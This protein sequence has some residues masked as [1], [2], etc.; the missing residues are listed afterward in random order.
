MRKEKGPD[1]PRVGAEEGQ[2]RL[3]QDVEDA[4][5][6]DDRRLG[7][8]VQPLQDQHI[9]QHGDGRHDQRADDPKPPRS[10]PTARPAPSPVTNQANTAPSMKNSPCA[11]LTTRIVPNVSDRPNRRQRQNRCRHKAFHPGQKKKC[12]NPMR[13]G[14]G[15]K[16][17]PRLFRSFARCNPPRRHT[18]PSSSEVLWTEV[19]LP[20]ST[21][22]ICWMP[23]ADG[24][25]R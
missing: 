9:R 1:R 25:C 11:T 6:G 2:G 7:L 5:G 23:N 4:D 10:P 12:T 20:P 16:P 22:E 21:F 13:I 8:I 17:P 19:S 24:S 15:P 14:R 18:S 3:L